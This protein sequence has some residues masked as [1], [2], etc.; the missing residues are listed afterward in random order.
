MTTLTQD[1]RHG[2]Q[3]IGAFVITRLKQIRSAAQQAR[4]RRA[5]FRTTLNELSR[6]SDREL[7][8]INIPRAHLRRVARE[9]AQMEKSHE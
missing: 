6:L 2:T 7:A 8:D 9:A 4:K 3:G 1:R 5:V